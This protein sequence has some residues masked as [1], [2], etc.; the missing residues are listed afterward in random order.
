[1]LKRRHLLVG[2]A[3]TLAAA[4]IAQDAAPSPSP[5]PAPSARWTRAMP[6]SG[7]RLPVV[8]LGTWITFNIGR[9][10]AER[11]LR[12]EVLRRFLAAGGGVIDSSPMYGSAEQVVGELLPT[13]VPPARVFAAT[14]VWTPLDRAG[15]QQ[16]ADS[17]RLWKRPV[18]D[19]LQVHN[20]LNWPAHL[21]TLREAQARGTT[22][23]LGVTTSHGSRHDEM[24]RVL[25]TEPIDVLQIT[26]NPVDTRAEPLMQLAADRGAAVIVN[27]PFDGG[28][29]LARLADRPLPA[30]ARDLGA[31]TWSAAVLLWEV[32]HPA[33]TCAIPATRNPAHLDQNMA[34]LAC[35]PPSEDQRRRLGAALQDAIRAA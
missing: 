16:I 34:V 13:V 31:R 18:L 26:Y 30:I 20:L 14:K 15:P 23:Y 25:Q 3:A 24:R 10:P 28:A 2:P 4:A 21:R 27:R 9:D 19:L 1:M 35:A 11:T 33:V 8:G 5:A 22:R 17:Q 12:Q 6:Q 32:S 7:E 29:L